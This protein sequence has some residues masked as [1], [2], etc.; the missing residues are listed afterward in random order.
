MCVC[1]VCHVCVCVCVC[2]QYCA[3]GH[4]AA[5]LVRVHMCVCVSVRLCVCVSVR[6]C[7]CVSV[8]L[9]LCVCSTV[10]QGTW[11]RFGFVCI[12][13]CNMFV[14]E[15]ERESARARVLVR[16]RERVCLF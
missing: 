14:R 4:T 6:L 2:V 15:R 10:L 13:I 11:L 7:V 1:Y 8:C 3:A 9:R 5:D 16:A 12:H